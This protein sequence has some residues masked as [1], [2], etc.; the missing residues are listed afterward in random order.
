M[1]QEITFETVSLSSL[2]KV[3]PDEEIQDP[4]LQGAT[5]L[6]NEIYS[7]Q[8]AYR[9]EGK[10]LRPM[11]IRMHSDIQRHV[12]IRSV[13]VVPVEM[14]TYHDHDDD[15]LRVTPGLYPDP[16][17]PIEGFRLTGLPGQWRSIWIEVDVTDDI[18][19]GTHSIE[20]AFETDEGELLGR[21]S[22]DLVVVGI[23]LPK[24]TLIRTEWFHSDCLAA[25]YGVEVFSSEHWQW[26]RKYVRTAV[27]NGINMIL[28]PLFT[29]P[30]DTFIGGERQTVQLVGVE[31][32][33]D[34]YRFD[35]DRLEQWIRLCEDCGV[36]YFEFSH[37]FTQWGAKS[38]P[39]I[40]GQVNGE[41][42]QLFGWEHSSTGQEYQHFLEM[43]LPELRAFILQH[44][45]ESRVYFHIS[46]EPG[47]ADLE[48]YEKASRLIQKHM[49]EFS[50]IDAL[51]DY[52]FYEKGL[53]EKPIPSNDHIEPFI[54]NE[55]PDLWTYYCSGQYKGGVSNRFLNM[56]SYRN[57]IIGMQ[58]YKFRIAGFLHWGYNFWNSHLSKR[59]ID[60][61]RVMDGDYAYP[62]GDAYVVYPGESGPIESLRLRVF[63]EGIQDMR[64][65]QLLEQ[66]AGREQT[67]IWLEEGLSTPLAF[68]QYP[69][70]PSWILSKREYL[71]K[72]IV[73]CKEKRR[74]AD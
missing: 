48:I 34:G 53:V 44:Q 50:I 2:A 60:P 70:H 54:Q 25:Y 43:F 1:T 69:H 67:L 52:S 29:P 73:A 37:L 28:T 45:L 11:Q 59:T 8:I 61:Y 27:R 21:Q 31:Q 41:Q 22:F 32:Q 74:L 63:H 7:Y 12:Q 46:D 39:K 30:L 19:P 40:M 20:I 55:V 16:L 5:A 47:P 33:G 57:R 64:M 72:K 65:L 18:E 6:W 3:F 24:Q 4:V 58:L 62:A 23:E 56:P 66:L 9:C 42:K 71:I 68:H 38:A 36:E 15:V 26:I 51:S 49:G 35:F 17:Y 13:G 14:P 10:L